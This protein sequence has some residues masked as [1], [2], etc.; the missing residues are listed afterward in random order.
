MTIGNKNNKARKENM[1]A[2]PVK[3]S[4]GDNADSMEKA[5][6]GNRNSFLFI[7]PVVFSFIFVLKL[8][9]SDI[10]PYWLAVLVPGLNSRNRVKSV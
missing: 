5:K 9:Y 2:N 3:I 6:P 1:A 10:S 7:L 8:L 4:I